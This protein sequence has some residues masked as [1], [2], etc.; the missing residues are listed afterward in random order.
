MIEKNEWE[1]CKK[2]GES[3]ILYRVVLVKMYL[4]HMEYWSYQ[5]ILSV[6]SETGA[7]DLQIR[8]FA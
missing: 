3:R 6:V 4:G 2:A 7:E 8:N 1:F 5:T